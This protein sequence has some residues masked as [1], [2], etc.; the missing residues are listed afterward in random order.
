MRREIETAPRDGKLVILEDDAR[1]TYELARWSTQQSAW[2]GENGKP[3]AILPTHWL[4]LQRDKRLLPG[5]DE[6]L[7]KDAELCSPPHRPIRRILSLS[8]DPALL[9]WAPPQDD[10]FALGPDARAAVPF[11]RIE[12]RIVAS[13]PG[14]P[15]LRRLVVSSIAAAMISSSLIGMYF[16]VPITIYLTQNADQLDIAPIGRIWEQQTDVSGRAPAVQAQDKSDQTATWN[17][18]QATMVSQAAAVSSRKDEQALQLK[19]KAKTAATELQQS[20]QQEQTKT[21]ALMQEAKDARATATVSEQQRRALEEAQARAAALASE[22]A[23]TRREIETQA[24]QSQKT[25]DAAVQQK[26]AAESTIADLQQ[27]L[28]QEQTKTAALMQEAKAAR[29]TTTVSEQQRRAL[30]EAQARAAALASELAGT[31][32]EIETQAAQWQKTVDEA[33]QQKQAAESTSADL[34][35]SLQQEQTKTAALM[36]E[37]KAAQAT[38]TVS[39]QQRRA[40]E[41]AQART[42]A[43]ASELAGTRSEIETQAAQWQKMVDEAVQQ[44]RAAETTI[45]DLQQS[46]QQEQRKTAALMQEAKAQ[47]T[48]T[49]SEQ[50]RRALEEAQARTA[51][52]ASELAGTGREIQTQGAPSQ[53]TVDDAVQQKQAAVSTIAEHQ[54]HQRAEMLSSEARRKLKALATVSRKESGRAASNQAAEDAKAELK[55]SLH[56]KR[57]Q[58]KGIMPNAETIRTAEQPVSIEANGSEAA[59][60]LARAKALVA[61]GNIRAARDV[62]ERVAEMGSAQAI[63][64]LAETFDPKVLATWRTR[65]TQGDVTKARELYAR[66]YDGGIK[67]AKD[68]SDALAIGNGERKPASWFGREETDN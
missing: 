61:E 29:A 12:P 39:E 57:G 1:G 7:Q 65:G 63:F 10:A 33:A 25:V 31:R 40:L 14:Q 45:A 68:R 67:A 46:L 34:Q 37:A 22:L 21:A 30:E 55:P 26:Q 16:R 6:Y 19:R 23:G 62:L 48:T 49:A 32:R 9:E 52:L 36:Q 3:I 28:Q 13:Q 54:G 17:A 56:Q 58:P 51:A 66:A 8:P 59:G 11:P 35:Q 60:L 5:G 15:A 24:A 47:A 44:K 41:E 4:P 20:L 27:S 64:A 38:A 50:Q 2:V 42:A 43:L 18:G 53:K